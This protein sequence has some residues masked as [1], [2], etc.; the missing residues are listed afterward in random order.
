M[1]SKYGCQLKNA[2]TGTLLMNVQKSNNLF[3]VEF[4]RN[5]ETN[6][7]MKNEAIVDLWHKRYG[8]LNDQDLHYL[9]QYNLVLGLPI[10]RKF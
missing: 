6:L 7:V 10:I 4:S 2:S 9:S 1:F 3:A 8:H 5:E